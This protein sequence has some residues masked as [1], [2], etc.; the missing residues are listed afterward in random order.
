MTT[1]IVEM[2]CSHKIL[3]YHVL[4]FSLSLYCTSWFDC[5]FSFS[6]DHCW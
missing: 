2:F 1:D 6:S 5:F 4:V 3:L